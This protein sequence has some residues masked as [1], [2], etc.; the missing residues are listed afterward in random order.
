MWWLLLVACDP[1]GPRPDGL[2]RAV[3]TDGPRV[4]WDV[5]A[6]PLPEIPLP[7]DAATRLDPSTPTGRRLN[8]SEEAPTETERQ[9]R[10][11][12]NQMDGFGTYAPIYVSFDRPLDLAPIAAAHS[13]DWDFRDDLV[14]LLNVDR[15]CE[16][17]G[18]EVALEMGHGQIPVTLMD[19]GERSPDPLAPG[20]FRMDGRG[21]YFEFDDHADSNNLLFED[22]YEDLDDDGVLDPGEDLDGDGR[23][24]VPNF[25][26]P[27]ACLGEEPGTVAHDRC[28][29]D[30]LL[31]WYDRQSDTLILRSL[32]PLEQQCTYAVV[33]TRGL[34]GEDGE[35]IQSP[36]PMVNAADQTADLAA[37]PELLSRYGKGRDDVAFAWTFTT[38]SMT[39]DLEALRAGLYGSGPLA[40]LAEEFPVSGFRPWTRGELAARAGASERLDPAA[41]DDRLLPGACF[42]GAMTYLW[43]QVLGEWPAN[44]CSIEADLSAV[45][46][47]FGGTFRA[48]DLLVDRDGIATEAYPA[49]ADEVWSLDPAT[50]EAVYGATEVTFW[51]ALPIEKEEGCTPGN[52][53]GEPFCAPFPVILYGHGYGGSRAE[54]S[55][56]MGRHAAMGYAMCGLDYYGHGLNRWQQDPQAAFALAAAAPEFAALGVPDLPAL[57]TNGRDRDLDNDGLADPGADQWTADVFHTRDMVRQHALELTQFV[58]ILRHMDGETGDGAGGVLGDL[59]GDGR[60]ELGGPDNTIGAWGISLGGIVSGVLAGSEPGLDA[61]SPNAGGGGLTDLSSRST[62]AGVPE[63]VVL[64]ML[65]PL[66][67]ACLPADEH[68]RPLPVGEATDRDC[69]EGKGSYA[70]PY[71]GGQL[72]LA[73]L[74]QNN[75]R[76]ELHEF[77]RVEGVRPGDRIRVENLTNGE[78]AEKALSE[79]GWVRLAAAADALDPIERRSL[80]GLSGDAPGPG[81]A[82]DNTLLGDA[83]RITV[84][85][86]DGAVRGVVESFQDEV[87]FQG[88]VYGP[89]SA[90]VAMQDGL[91]Y[92]RNTPD[93]RRFVGIAQHAIAPADPATWAVHTR[94]EPLDVPYDPFRSGGNTRV[95]HMPTGGDSQVPVST[96][97]AAARAAGVLGDWRRDESLPAE[98]GWRA[99]FVPDPRL[100]ATPDDVLIDQYVVEGDDRLQRWAGY[101]LNPNVLFDVDDVSDGAAAW[102]CGPSDW[103]A[104]NGE[105]ECPAE[106]LGQEVFFG[107]PHPP[108]GRALRRDA[109]RGDGT[110]DALRVPLLRPAGQHGIYNAQAFRPF[111]ADAYMVNFTV[112]YLGSR[113]ADT[114]HRA[115]CDCASSALPAFSVGGDPY[116]PGLDRACEPADLNV[117]DASCAADFGIVTPPAAACAP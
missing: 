94:L 69:L 70:G 34:T 105:N 39:R 35:P 82:D 52:P 4:R 108:D 107:A 99:L 62:Q 89:G 90:L 83:L 9:V 68:D 41:A 71:A 73:F 23:L 5:S 106:F 53:D 31:S 56:H 103:S 16:R 3:R 115:G 30:H 60:P 75:A 109:P 25:L 47:A 21:V 74:V 77:A 66:V 85:G 111:D 28:V 63:A 36:F 78:R 101:D 114:R 50:G 38:G 43:G 7:N 8:I 67:A 96:G 22:R 14:Y 87:T 81:R 49:N 97:I 93:L 92:E 80:I 24:D 88:T 113:G 102:S 112:N 27:R 10:R 40:R 65:G 1:S 15:G 33:L 12:F 2:A 45:G 42:G 58:R 54:I 29:A 79:R 46:H 20:G 48:P 98:H 37:V 104:L 11:T 26:D 110:F 17:F 13:D 55:L 86:P 44:M 76:R 72:R 64:P 59:D 84:T 61:V 6:R 19:R 91:G 100:G 116:H 95:L 18:E 51:C 117:C 57:L 32:W